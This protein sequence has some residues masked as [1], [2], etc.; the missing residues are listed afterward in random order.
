MVL[1]EDGTPVEPG[2][3]GVLYVR[4]PHVMVGYWRKPGADRGDDRRGA[5]PRRA[6]ALRAG[7]L[8]GG[9]GRLPL[10][11]RAQRRHHQDARRE[12]QPH[13]GRERDLRHRG[14]Q[15]GGRRSASPTRCSAR[16]SGRSSS[17]TTGAKLTEQDVIA[18]CR[19]RLENF[20]VP[21]E[22]E[23]LDALPT[24]ATGKVR[25][26]SLKD[27][28]RSRSIAP[29][30]CPRRPRQG[31][32]PDVAGGDGLVA[33]CLRRTAAACPGGTSV[34]VD[35]RARSLSGG[36]C[37]RGTCRRRSPRTRRPAPSCRRCRSRRRRRRARSRP[38][39]APPPAPPGCRS[40]SARW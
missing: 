40:G 30:A 39:R 18:A 6:D 1:R 27:P 8:H 35:R 20:M 19:T 26:K 23:F 14:R 34:P 33:R 10:L 5:A 7:S 28:A 37:R 32:D 17:S 4:G 31:S 11:R 13:R 38:W 21:Q 16:R 15:G 12:G 22:V 9:R 36:R 24:T 25:R 2:E 29:Q 3:T